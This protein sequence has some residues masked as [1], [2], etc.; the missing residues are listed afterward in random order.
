VRVDFQRPFVA[1]EGAREV[2]LVRHGSIGSPPAERAEPPVGGQT[3][4]SLNDDGEAQARAVAA[5]LAGVPITAVVVSPLRRTSETAAPLLAGRDLEPLVLADL[6]EV[7]LGDWEHGELSRRAARSDP[8]F[9]Q[10]MREQRWDVI[11][12]AE[13]DEDFAARVRRGLEAAA[14][15]GDGAGPVA[16]FT[17]GGVIAE[18]CRQVTGSE[19]FAF[20]TVM[21]GSLTRLVRLPGGR[22]LL[23]GFNET[24]HLP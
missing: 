16:V 3:N 19:P 21:N 20:L 11:P 1:P 23:L 15:A 14:D 8:D 22:W 4:R 13:R 17:H 10:V 18:A 24:A 6:R 9:R 5:R 12:N 7:Q 2:L